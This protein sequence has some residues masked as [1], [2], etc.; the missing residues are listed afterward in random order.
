MRDQA[1]AFLSRSFDHLIA[2]SAPF[3]DV[4]T[5]DEVLDAIVGGLATEFTR[6]ALFRVVNN[7]LT[8]GQHLGFDFPADP[9]H[10]VIPHSIDAVLERAITS[11]QIEL[12][13]DDA[14]ADSAG[15][16]FGGTPTCSLALPI[17]LGDDTVAVV[18]ADDAEHPH[19]G[20]A[21]ADLRRKF[22][23]LL[24][25]LAMPLL[26]R[27]PAEVKAIGEL[28]EYALRLVVE[29]ENM[30]AADIGAHKN[31]ADLRRRLR[32]NLECARGIYTQRISSES[33]AAAD[34]LEEQLAVAVARTRGTAFGRDLAALV[35]A[36]QPL[37]AEA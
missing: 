1:V 8:I 18:Y 13:S 3:A 28:R 23:L 20:F 30:H 15:T 4:S 21:S 10:L 7:S 17:D 19:Q 22:A 11:G 35:T 24:R 37:A 14:L 5:E 29:L 9:T 36:P 12:L 2:L 31:A 32:D 34:L 25:Q 33:P 26:Q 6:V 16:P 27:L